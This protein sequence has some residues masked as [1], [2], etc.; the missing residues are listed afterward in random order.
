MRSAILPQQGAHGEGASKM[1]I[2]ARKVKS[3]FKKVL[4][5]TKFSV[6]LEGSLRAAFRLCQTS[7][8]SLSILHIRKNVSP[9]GAEPCVAVDTAKLEDETLTILSHLS[10]RARQAGVNCRTRSDAGIPSEK[11]LEAIDE[12]E[13]N[14][15]I[16][17]TS[18]P[19]GSK[20][21]VFGPTADVVMRLA[22]CPI[23]TIGPV[24]ADL[25]K[26][27]ASKGPVIFATDFHSVTREAIRV[28]VS[29]CRSTGL[30]LHCLHVL[31]RTLQSSEGDRALPEILTSA[32][33]HLA[34]TNAEGIDLPV[35]CVTFGSEISNAIVDYIRSQQASLIFLGVRRSSLI[36]SDEP[37]PIVFRI[38][39]EA[40]CPVVTIV[41]ETD[42]EP[43]LSRSKMSELSPLRLP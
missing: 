3:P 1:K 22:P 26:T 28:A 32:L 19:R 33:R 24:A 25:M 12:E 6:S 38:I 20:R 36:A 9:S 34:A 16:L 4:L 35:C 13:I 21:L 39:T 7:D 17:G 31:P 2:I 18:E 15:T 41:C 11:I 14:L 42:T 40:S 5:A 43:S 37:L 8:A 23:M 10:D 27:S 30:R 29:Y